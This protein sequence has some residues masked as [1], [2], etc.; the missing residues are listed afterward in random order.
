VTAATLS[1]RLACLFFA[2]AL[3]VARPALAEA[4]AVTAADR[5]TRSMPGADSLP[6]SEAGAWSEAV[7]GVQGRLVVSD[8]QDANGVR[9]PDVFLE[10]QNVSDVMNPIEIYYDTLHPN[11]SCDLVDAQGNVVPRANGPADVLLPLSFWLTL[12]QGALL[13]FKISV[14]GYLVAKGNDISLQMICGDWTLKT[15]DDAR[16]LRATLAGTASEEGQGRR[17]WHG[18][19][20]LPKV[21][22]R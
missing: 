8:G 6:G 21:R 13:R 4:P 18:T 5:G 2:L 20:A 11:L 1:L 12:P 17:V 7:D 3:V 14:R 10:L 22:V 19:L 9:F 16:F 15:A